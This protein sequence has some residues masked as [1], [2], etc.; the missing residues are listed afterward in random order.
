[1]APPLNLDEPW[2]LD[3]LLSLPP[4]KNCK[5]HFIAVIF[6][7]SLCPPYYLGATISPRPISI[8]SPTSHT[9]LAPQGA[10][11]AHLDEPTENFIFSSR[12][13]SGWLF[14]VTVLNKFP[15]E[16]WDAEGS[17]L[18]LKMG[19]NCSKLARRLRWYWFKR[20]RLCLIG[21]IKTPKY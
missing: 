4:A 10:H 16:I 9:P 13:D 2:K 14:V 20:H 17:Y 3:S 21:L 12:S 5:W 8:L 11:S 6:D 19:V 15:N 7:S 18:V 1:M